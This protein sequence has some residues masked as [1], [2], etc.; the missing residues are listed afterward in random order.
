MK[1]SAASIFYPNSIEVYEKY[2]PEDPEYEKCT[3]IE[4]M[5]RFKYETNGNKA[6]VYAAKHPLMRRNLPGNP[7]Q[8]YERRKRQ[9]VRYAFYNKISAGL[10]QYYYAKLMTSVSYR[11]NLISEANKSKTFHEEAIIRNLKEEIEIDFI[12]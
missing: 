2:R 9:V 8:F 1:D 4:F 11:G 6:P 7:Y 5:R 12:E 3:Y 10:E